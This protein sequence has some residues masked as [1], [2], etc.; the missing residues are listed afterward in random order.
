MIPVYEIFGPTIQGEGPCVGVR[1]IFVR[2]VGCDG[3]C[4]FCDSKYT[5]KASDKMVEYTEDNLAYT[6]INKCLS[7]NTNHI[8]IT[9]GN[10]CLHD[11]TKVID[12]VKTRV[13]GVQID[14]ETQG[15][16]LPEWL[17]KIDTLVFSPKAPSSGTEDTYDKINAYITQS[18]AFIDRLPAKQNIAIKIPVFNEEDINFARK[19]AR[20]VNDAYHCLY[21]R[22]NKSN[23]RFYLSVGNTDVDDTK[24]IKDRILDSYEK[25]INYVNENPEDFENA[26]ILPQIHTLVWG[27]KSGV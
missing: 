13:S 22:Y 18:E 8:V 26:Y 10:P 23:L 21:H 16:V 11:F 27:N 4:W 24:P 6:L 12:M 2:T 5:W 1:T 19:F 3:K 9:G 20:I 14:V 25:L 7:T 15:S 17:S